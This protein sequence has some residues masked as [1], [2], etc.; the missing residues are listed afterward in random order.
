[1]RDLPGKEE[2]VVRD[3]KDF[4]ASS[5]LEEE[6]E[7]W[8]VASMVDLSSAVKGVFWGLSELGEGGGGVREGWREK[9]EGWRKE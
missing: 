1:M 4:Q 5:V 9:R 2:C 3:L 6:R 7:W 8:R